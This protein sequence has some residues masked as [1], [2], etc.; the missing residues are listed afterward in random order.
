MNPGNNIHFVERVAK[1]GVDVAED[2]QISLTDALRKVAI[3][4]G[5]NP[6]QAEN[7]GA[8]MNHIKFAREKDRNGTLTFKFEKADYTQLGPL[9]EKKAKV[10]EGK[11]MKTASELLGSVANEPSPKINPIH[12]IVKIADAAEENADDLLSLVN[13][14]DNI[15][16]HI[17]NTIIA[18]LQAG[19]SA[20]DIYRTL[21]ESWGKN[22]EE[23]L[24]KY[25]T[26]LLDDLKTEGYIDQV[27]FNVPDYTNTDP[28]ELTDNEL[29]K[30]AHEVLR[31]SDEIIKREIAH[32]NMMNMLQK[33]GGEKRAAMID[34]Y[35]QHEF[36][37]ASVLQEG[38]E[39]YAGVNTAAKIFFQE[40]P[41]AY[42]AAIVGAQIAAT[43]G[44]DIIND[45]TKKI[46]TRKLEKSLP[47]RFPGLQEIP[48]SEYHDIYETVTNLNPVLVTAPY[49]LAQTL[50]KHHITGTMDSGNI[51]QMISA[52][53]NYTP[54]LNSESISKAVQT[55]MLAGAKVVEDQDKMDKEHDFKSD[56]A[57]YINEKRKK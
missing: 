57:I 11:R 37:I 40:K 30:S 48:P 29:A 15:F 8:R 19:E 41:L 16:A 21:Y 28:V 52:G 14:R 46:R 53:K 43:K 35:L 55:G 26:G 7:V 32:L 51:N 10:I 25:F 23:E 13:K 3:D 27:D 12:N 38:L 44:V 5:L 47:N 22:N 49:A 56:L 24:K 42:L 2:N 45:V 54:P 36:I 39:K 18:L 50:K 9:V 31:Y 1:A 20:N 34:K 6:V 4:Y 17:K 33:E